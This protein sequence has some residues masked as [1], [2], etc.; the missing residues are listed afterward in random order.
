MWMSIRRLKNCL[1]KRTEVIGK[2]IVLTLPE[3]SQAADD[4]LQ[5]RQSE[6]RFE[7]VGKRRD[8]TIFPIIIHSKP[9]VY[10]AQEMRIAAVHDLTAA[11]QTEQE[12]LD[13][14]I[15][16]NRVTLLENLLNDLSHDL[17]TPIASISFK[18]AILEMVQDVVDREKEIGLMK[19]QL[20]QIEQMMESILLM[21][22]LEQ[23]MLRKNEPVHLNAIAEDV[24]Q[25]L[26]LQAAARGITLQLELDPAMPMLAGDFTALWRMLLNL[27]KNSIA[28]SEPQRTVVIGTSV[29]GSQVVLKVE[30]QGF[31]IVP[32]DI[33]HIFDRHYRS[34]HTQQ[35]EGTGLGLAIVKAVVEAHHGQIEVE[36]VPRQGTTFYV[37]LPLTA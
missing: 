24:A 27:V 6:H 34:P 16:R 12:R 25:W 36:S 28:Y 15:Q 32:E 13:L 3:Y 11:R 17:K 5:Q 19:K 26:Q 29:E 8:G 2:S 20:A 18:L 21:S 22:R 7:S 14:A 31:G 35:V 4:D 9:I 33:A 30:D 37:R 1:A 10:R 23:G